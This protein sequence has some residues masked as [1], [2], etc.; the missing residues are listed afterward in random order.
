MFYEDA[1]RIAGRDHEWVQYTLT[2]KVDMFCRTGIDANLDK[3][4]EMIC[5]PGF[6]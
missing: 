5:M 4:K 2:V 3:T 1:I 6:I